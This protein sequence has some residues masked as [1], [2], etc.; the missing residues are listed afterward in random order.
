MNLL[1]FEFWPYFLAFT[2][3]YYFM[4]LRGQ[5]ILLAAANVAFIASWGKNSVVIQISSILMSYLIYAKITDEK[6]SPA[7]KKKITYSYIALQIGILIYFKATTKILPLGISYYTFTIIAFL[8]ETLWKRTS[9]KL[10]PLEYIMSVSFFP[11]IMMGPIERLSKFSLQFRTRRQ[12]STEALTSGLYYIA[13]GLFK[14]TTI[15]NPLELLINHTKTPALESYGLGLMLY[16]VLSFM[17]LYAEFSGFIDVVTGLTT[18]LGLK[19]TKNF[20]Q[21]Y[22]ATN[23][24]DIWKRWHISLT[25]WLRD[26]VFVPLVLKT[27]NIAFSSIII[28]LMVGAWHGI[29]IEFFYWS[30]YWT[31][32]YVLYLFFIKFAMSYRSITL[33][34]K[35][36]LKIA[37]TFTITSFSTL[38]FMIPYSGLVN[39]TKRFF[40]ITFES[41]THFLNILKSMQINLSFIVTSILVMV[42]LESFDKNHFTKYR[43]V[44]IV[45]LCFLIAMLGEFKLHSL[46]YL[47]I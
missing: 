9:T 29:E 35:K 23:V 33:I 24:S 10:N 36:P 12:F 31:I 7:F 20:D 13:L 15:T 46:I 44:K 39:L 42:L 5:N 2:F 19:I 28:L 16:C 45:A 26:F 27:K 18:L 37:L 4:P 41:S 43:K 30:L 11:I 32:F 22:F 38:S 25:L 1:T 21:P 14:I 3:I 40:S 6:S 8:L 34:H 17:K 47:R